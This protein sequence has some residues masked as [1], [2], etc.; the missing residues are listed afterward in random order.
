MSENNITLGRERDIDITK[1][2]KTS[3]LSYAMSV[4]V[5]RALPDVRD[6]LKPVHRRIIYGMNELGITSGSAYKKSARIVGEVMGKYHPHGDSSIY[7]AMVRMSQDFA[8]RLPLINGHGNFGSID[9]DGAAAM[10]YTEAKMSKIAMELIKD[11]NKNTIDYRDNYDGSE[12]EPIV[13]PSKFPNLLVNGST[14]IAVG[15]ATNI[16]PHNLSETI[17]A[18]IALMDNPEISIND[19]IGYIKGPDFPTGGIIMGHKGLKSAYHTGNG[20]IILRAK[21]EIEVSKSGKESIIITE[22]PYQVNKT[23]LIEKISELVRNKKLEG[24]TGLSDQSSL[25]VGMRIVVEVSKNNSAAIVRNNLYKY[26][27]LQTTFSANMVALVNNQP[28]VLNL[29]QCLSYYLDHQIEVLV[30]K[31]QFDLNKA[32]ARAHIVQ[33]LMIALDNIDAVID[34][35]RNSPS[36]DVAR[37]NLMERFSLSEVQASAILDM[38]LNKLT[39]LEREKLEMEFED[40]QNSIAEFKSI[41]ESRTRQLTIIKEDL[42]VIKDRYSTDRKTSIELND[43]EIDNEAL[44]EQ[45]EVI[46]T[47]TNKG[48]VKRITA[49]SYKL[50][51]RG[52]KGSRGAKTYEGD[53]IEQVLYTGTHDHLLFFTDLGK[54]YKMKAY[55]IPEASKTSKGLPIINLL[56]LAKDESLAAVLRVTEEDINKGYLF[57]GTKRGLVKRTSLEEFK[58]IRVNGI[59]AI[60]LKDDD[61]LL[62]VRYTEGNNDII[63]GCSNG[64]AIRFKETDVRETG[65]SSSGVRGMNIE[66]S[67]HIVGLTVVSKEKNQILV[68]TTNGY[69]KRTDVSEY[70]VQ[71]RGC[72]G[73]KTLNLTD[74]N[75]QLVKLRS[76]NESSDVLLVTTSGQVIRQG[77]SQISKTGR[78]TQ[79]VILMKVND[80]EKIAT[81]AIVPSDDDA[82][83]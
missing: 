26:T 52:G 79:G 83:E 68:V 58:N 40:L 8:Y 66:E 71:T 78:S 37:T 1:E 7:D 56:N 44:I 49:D 48:Y 39:G 19:L 23:R 82:E 30:R 41:L 81:I 76:V 36:T 53:F 51:N 50:Q 16:P 60:S 18:L 69:G 42:A 61:S 74:K 45:E 75:G 77:I 13:L 4:I 35:I 43:N 15:L 73:V 65:R 28:K 59:R 38:R 63:L 62:S 3:F 20:Q 47:I 5:S 25:K 29:K 2:M 80:K 6:G 46:I 22:I 11:I 9:G 55:N 21:S 70:R 17:D 54:V 72:K 24:I 67:E 10:R 27:S 31:T 14:G 64:K 32:E 57:F 33:G 12:R 34:V